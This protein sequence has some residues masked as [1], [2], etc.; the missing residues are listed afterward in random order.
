[1]SWDSVRR[2]LDAL[3]DAAFGFRFCPPSPAYAGVSLAALDDSDMKIVGQVPLRPAKGDTG[4][5]ASAYVR[6]KE[7]GSIQKAEQ[8][9]RQLSE[10]LNQYDF[11][12]LGQI[13]TENSNVLVHLFLLCI[14]SIDHTLE[15]CFSSQLLAQVAQNKLIEH[16]DSKAVYRDIRANA[17]YSMYRLAARSRDVAEEI[18]SAF[19]ELCQKESDPAYQEAGT[20]LYLQMAGKVQ[21]LLTA[22]RF[23]SGE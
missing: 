8:L 17:A 22:A 2:R 12:P 10:M 3:L 7:D 18:G 16:L 15:H 5:D 13:D 21:E 20:A 19:A 23:P 11:S 4:N 9:G 1:M 6:A 14:F